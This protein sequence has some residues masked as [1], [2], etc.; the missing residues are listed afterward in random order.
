M[1]TLNYGIEASQVSP[2]EDK[3]GNRGRF[4]VLGFL[5]VSQGFLG[6]FVIVLASMFDH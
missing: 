2:L 5:R 1:G 4:G 6:V 3:R